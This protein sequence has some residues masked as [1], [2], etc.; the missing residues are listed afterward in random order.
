MTRWL[1]GL[2]ALA[3]MLTFGGCSLETA[4]D[5]MSSEQ[6]RRFAQDVVSNLRAGNA[7]WLEAR[8]QGGFWSRHGGEV[9]RFGGFLQESPGETK[10]VGYQMSR[11]TASGSGS[12]RSQAFVLVSKGLGRWVVTHLETLEE[13]GGPRRIVAL[14]VAPRSE[15]PPELVMFDASEKAVPYLWG[16]AAAFVAML[17]AILW[18]WLRFRRR[19]RDAA[20]PR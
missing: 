2:A 7:K 16:I 9:Q 11:R 14:R 3:A 12:S 13:N 5:A 10:L 1:R 8:S 15:A 6:D 17:I 19:K 4:I 18:A 20:A